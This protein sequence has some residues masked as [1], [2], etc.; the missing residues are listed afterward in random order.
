MN[1]KT[2]GCFTDFVVVV[3]IAAF[4]Y[5]AVAGIGGCTQG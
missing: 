2:K 3:L 1:N 4:A 5:V